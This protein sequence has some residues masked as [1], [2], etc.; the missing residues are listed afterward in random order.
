MVQE[1]VSDDDHREETL[2]SDAETAKKATI[3]EAY[4]LPSVVTTG[5]T[6]RFI[7]DTDAPLHDES[8][9]AVRDK[10]MDVSEEEVSNEDDC[11]SRSRTIRARN[12]IEADLLDHSA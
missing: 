1:I 8:V 9:I 4:T 10:V 2:Q 7:Q 11:L 3:N 6:Q 5:K 12:K